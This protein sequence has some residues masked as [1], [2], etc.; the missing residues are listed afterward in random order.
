[1]IAELSQFRAAVGV[2]LAEQLTLDGGLDPQVALPPLESLR[3]EARNRHPALALSRSEVRQ[4]EARITYE[5]ALAR[6][7][8]A[9]RSDVERYPDVPNFR[10]GI[11]IPLPFWNKR[12]GPIA[13]S[14]GGITAD[15]IPLR[16]PGRL[17]FWPRW[18]VLTNVINWQASSWRR[19]SKDFLKKQRKR[20]GQPRPRFS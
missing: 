19:S 8:P 2:P 17:K 7:Q 16:A 12:E 3:D 11:E 6:P 13:E 9:V 14:S 5:R 15:G 4:A 10:F 20:F 18:K 1:M